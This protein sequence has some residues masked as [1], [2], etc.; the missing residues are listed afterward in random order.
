MERIG[1]AVA[2]D[3]QP[4]SFVPAAEARFSEVGAVPCPS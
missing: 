1:P 2:H 4:L 3:G